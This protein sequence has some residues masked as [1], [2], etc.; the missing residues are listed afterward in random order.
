L[1]FDFFSSD[2]FS[3]S[4]LIFFYS[5]LLAFTSQ[6]QH[7][8]A[9]PLAHHNHHKTSMLPPLKWQDGLIFT[10]NS[11]T[12]SGWIKMDSD[13]DKILAF[14][15][16]NS[17][18]LSKII[19]VEE[20]QG[21]RLFAYDTTFGRSTKYTDY[22]SVKKWKG[23]YRAIVKGKT[24]LFD[25]TGYSD[26]IPGYINYNLL[27]IEKEDSITLI[28]NSKKKLIEMINKLFHQQFV[29]KNFKSKRDAIKW[30]IIHAND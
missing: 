21:I 24:S 13:F 14:V 30:I 22:I 20:V 3:T 12:I 25:N 29:S 11:D 8:F 6:G 19:P 15:G 1:T 26:E 9:P 7:H 2:N 23:L 27:L 5:I 17:K 16:T 4:F 10:S 18:P 28:P